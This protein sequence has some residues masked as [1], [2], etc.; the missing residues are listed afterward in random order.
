MRRALLILP[1]AA[2][3]AAGAAEPVPVPVPVYGCAIPAPQPLAPRTDV[4]ADV[5]DVLSGDVEV[6]L[7]GLTIFKDRLVLRRRD[8]QRGADS[9]RSVRR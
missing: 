6:D 2:A 9:A 7:N 8:I 1:W 3:A 5:L 4:G